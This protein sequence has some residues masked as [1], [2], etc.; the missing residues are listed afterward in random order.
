[1]VRKCLENGKWGEVNNSFCIDK[2]PEVIEKTRLVVEKDEFIMLCPA[3]IHAS[4][5]LH[6]GT[7]IIPSKRISLQNKGKKRVLRIFPVLL[8]DAG[9]YTCSST[10]TLSQELVVKPLPKFYVDPRFEKINDLKRIGFKVINEY[11]DL[12]K[13]EC[14]IAETS[15]GSS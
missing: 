11:N 2:K 7:A 1:M 8:S 14:F 5:W 4:E 13:I 12:V 3:P 10:Q 6:N 15:E 9:Q